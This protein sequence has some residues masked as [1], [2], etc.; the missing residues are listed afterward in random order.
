MSL[1]RTYLMSF[2]C[3]ITEH[4][5]V[6]VR[7]FCTQVTSFHTSLLLQVLSPLST[8]EHLEFASSTLLFVHDA[9]FQS[10]LLLPSTEWPRWKVPSST[11]KP[12]A[13]MNKDRKVVLLLPA[14][15]ANCLLNFRFSVGAIPTVWILQALAGIIPARSNLLTPLSC[16]L[17]FF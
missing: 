8:S 15:A 9:I 6:P 3:L 7:P 2:F 14:T 16:I 12:Y 4:Q 5:C 17:F 11:S 13:S 10:K 1:G